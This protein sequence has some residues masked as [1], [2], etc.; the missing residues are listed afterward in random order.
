MS[1]DPSTHTSATMQVPDLLLMVTSLTIQE[2]LEILADRSRG[3][4]AELKWSSCRE[5]VSGPA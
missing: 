2:A 5:C 3:E 1:T 4:A